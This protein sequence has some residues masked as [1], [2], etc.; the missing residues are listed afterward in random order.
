VNFRLNRG[1]QTFVFPIRLSENISPSA[2][3]YGTFVPFAAYFLVKKLI[4][5]P[6]LRQQKEK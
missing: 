4:V 2:I 6:Y 3:F 1:S 5:D